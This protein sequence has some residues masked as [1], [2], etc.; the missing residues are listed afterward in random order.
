MTTALEKEICELY[1]TNLSVNSLALLM[2]IGK[3]KI[4]PILIKHGIYEPDRMPRIL[5]TPSQSKLMI[6]LYNDK[7]MSMNELG[8]HFG[9]D[10]ATI[11]KHLVSRGTRIKGQSEAQSKALNHFTFDT[12]DSHE[13]AYW[14]GFLAADGSVSKKQVSLHLA[15]R[16]IKQIEKFHAFLGSG[17]KITTRPVP[18]KGKVH[19]LSGFSFCSPKIM[20]DLATHNILRNKSKVYPFSS[21]IPSQFLNAYILGMIDGDGSF[22]VSKSGQA[23]MNLMATYDVCSKILEIFRERG[24]VYTKGRHIHKSGTPGLFYLCVGG[25]LQ[26]KGI[27]NWLYES[28]SDFA[29]PRKLDRVE[30]HFKLKYRQQ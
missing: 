19:S 22:G 26:V 27:C 24:L 29:L 14:V 20:S 18:L 23:H 10:P 6:E 16:D 3:K 12:I 11:K 13:K 2:G 8:V 7:T 1:S 9:V 28:N 17:H 25:N 30:H 21:N 4:V 5:F 15:T